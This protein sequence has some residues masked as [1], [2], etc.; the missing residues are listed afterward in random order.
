[1]DY[2]QILQKLP[3]RN[4]ALE[5]IRK[6][7][8]IR[9]ATKDDVPKILEIEDVSFEGFDRFTE[10][11]FFLYL[12]KFKDG[13][14]VAVDECGSIFGYAIMSNTRRC[15]YVLSIAVHP[16]KRRQGCAKLL[17]KAMESR[18]QEQQ[19]SK[20]RLEVRV[21]NKSAVELYKKIGL[22]KVGTRKNF[23]GDGLDALTMEKILD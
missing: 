14:F 22:V 19:F 16:K 18:C 15:G 3:W 11:L 6:R 13:F 20:L 7:I 5:N 4:I 21:E 8:E 17:M 12:V 1:M 23:Y 10:S 9:T 2:T